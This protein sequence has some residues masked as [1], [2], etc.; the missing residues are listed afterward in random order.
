ME[1]L[2]NYA[3]HPYS[4]LYSILLLIALVYWV[5][6]ILGVVDLNIA[7]VDVD[8]DLDIDIQ[9]D[10]E[11]GIEAQGGGFW[12]EVLG[13][14][15]FGKLPFML[16]FTCFI[17]FQWAASIL[18]HHLITEDLI[19]TL[20]LCIPSM[21]LCLFLSKIVLQPLLPLFEKMMKEEKDVNYIGK[22]GVVKFPAYGSKLGQAEVK[23]EDKHLRIKITPAK[24]QELKRGDRIEILQTLDSKQGFIVKKI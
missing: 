2:Y 13:F 1:E 15:H 7:D 12:I 3:I 8:L 9:G 11:S 19:I 20:L 23:I 16:I 5:I 10:V 21:M 17:F 18:I 24:N 6:A 22:Q 14:F 4:L